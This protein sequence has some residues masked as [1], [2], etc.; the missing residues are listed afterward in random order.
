MKMETVLDS[1]SYAA[2]N[3][4]TSLIKVEDSEQSVEENHRYGMNREEELIF[5]SIKEEEEE[6]GGRQNEEVKREDRVK[7]EEEER[8]DWS[9]KTESEWDESED[10]QTGG[11]L[12]FKLEEEAYSS[13]VPGSFLEQSI[14]VSP[15][16]PAVSS[17]EGNA[18]PMEP[19]EDGDEYGVKFGMYW[20]SPLVCRHPSHSKVTRHPQK[21]SRNTR[22]AT[23]E[24]ARAVSQKYKISFPIGTSV[25]LDHRM[26]ETVSG[27]KGVEAA[28]ADDELQEDT[29]FAAGSKDDLDNFVSNV[30]SQ[31]SVSPMKFQIKSPVATLASSH[32]RYLNQKYKEYTSEFKR[33]A[34]EQIAPGQGSDLEKLLSSDTDSDV[35]DFLATLQQEYQ[36]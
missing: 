25:C 26:H 16:S 17:T 15:G 32:R 9:P 19:G 27:A 6:G 13:I 31:E 24:I 30:I 33:K 35:D 2:M 8:N 23:V 22:P 1:N 12:D 14:A 21:K 29:D 11:I 3:L 18:V 10:H 7:D 36:K 5:S 4:Q 20:K 28:M 34:C